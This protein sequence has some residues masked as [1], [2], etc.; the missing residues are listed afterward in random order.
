MSHVGQRPSQRGWKLSINQEVQE[1][2]HSTGWSTSAAAKARQARMSAASKYGKSERMFYSVSPSASK[3]RTS[4]TLIRIPRM[5]GL[6]PHWFGLKVMRD[7]PA[8]IHT[9]MVMAKQESGYL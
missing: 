2:V 1:V 9:E 7:I 5:Q 6:P 3:S 4:L 8:M